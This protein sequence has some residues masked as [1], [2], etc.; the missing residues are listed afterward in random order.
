MRKKLKE[1]PRVSLCEVLLILKSKFELKEY[2]SKKDQMTQ[3]IRL[4]GYELNKHPAD[5]TV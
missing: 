2:E 5:K 3:K 1:N 4:L